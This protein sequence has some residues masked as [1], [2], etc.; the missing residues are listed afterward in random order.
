M[1]MCDKVE[2]HEVCVLDLSA[3]R[4]HFHSRGFYSVMFGGGLYNWLHKPHWP[5]CAYNVHSFM[6]E[7]YLNNTSTKL[8]HDIDNITKNTFFNDGHNKI[9]TVLNYEARAD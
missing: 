1:H 4:I 5:Y 7:F 6:T 3:D 2:A 9:S 8:F